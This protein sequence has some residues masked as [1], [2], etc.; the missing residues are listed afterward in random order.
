[1]RLHISDC[2]RD[3]LDKEAIKQGLSKSELAN[4]LLAQYFQINLPPR[5]QMA[6][7][8]NNDTQKTQL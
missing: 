8:K 1:M 5:Q 7:D 2:I 4:K 6:K 3:A